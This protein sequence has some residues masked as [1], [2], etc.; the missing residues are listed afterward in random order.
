MTVT[1]PQE[2]VFLIVQECLNL[3]KKSYETV[4]K[5]ARVIGLLVSTFSTVEYG[6][7]HYRELEKE[8]IQALRRSYG[9]FDFKMLVT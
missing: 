7:L 6:P 2:K 4:R 8:K 9:E 1:L 5:V 3:S